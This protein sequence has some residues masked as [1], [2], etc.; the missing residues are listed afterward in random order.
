MAKGAEAE[1]FIAR[2]NEAPFLFEVYHILSLFAPYRG[3]RRGSSEI[4][5][6]KYNGQ[7]WNL[8]KRMRGQLDPPHEPS[9]IHKLQWVRL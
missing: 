4:L 2:S 9:R 6:V 1:H 5:G 3:K 8:Y 7:P